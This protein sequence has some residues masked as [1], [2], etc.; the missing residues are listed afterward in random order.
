MKITLLWFFNSRYLKELV[1]EFGDVV[2]L[3]LG[4]QFFSLDELED[5]LVQIFIY[6]VWLRVFI[7]SLLSCLVRR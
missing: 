6:L 2:A 3:V 1:V 4:W 5:L 7:L